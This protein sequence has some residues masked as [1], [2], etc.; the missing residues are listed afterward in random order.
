M[1]SAL[2]YFT[3]TIMPGHFDLGYHLGV[4]VRYFVFKTNFCTILPR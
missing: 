4:S 3:V 2:T 1:A